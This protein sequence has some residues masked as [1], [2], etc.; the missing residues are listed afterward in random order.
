M[1][2]FRK[3][4]GG[5][6]EIGQVEPGSV[7]NVPLH[8]L[9]ATHKELF[10]SIANY[11][12]SVQGFNWK[13]NPSDFKYMK[14][15]QCDPIHTYEPFY[16]TAIREREEV[17]H[18]VTSKFTMLSACYVISLKPPLYL[19]N[20]LPI[21][22]QISVAGCTVSQKENNCPKLSENN[23]QSVNY[24]GP[25][26]ASLTKSDFLDSGEKVVKPG[27]LLHLPTVKTTAK[28][29]ERRSLIVARVSFALNT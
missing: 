28:E 26:N 22:I 27:D 3:R 14:F 10:F 12:T 21:D 29:G 24:N 11:K 20:A 6:V 5:L 18:E 13:E 15:L 17:Y 4:N 1:N 2:I 25:F 23:H 16:I 9:Y 19:R 8:A 7:F